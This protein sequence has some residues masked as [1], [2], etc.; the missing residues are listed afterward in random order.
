MRK[1]AIVLGCMLAYAFLAGFGP[2][3]PSIG[4][5]FSIGM[6]GVMLMLPIGAVVWAVRSFRS[7]HKG[8]HRLMILEGL[9]IRR[10]S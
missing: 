5:P 6:N 8:F 3:I 7:W 4:G 1:L 10:S 9:R 2:V